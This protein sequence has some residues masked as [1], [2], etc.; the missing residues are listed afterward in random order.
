MADAVRID[1]RNILARYLAGSPPPAMRTMLLSGLGGFLAIFALTVPFALR[2]VLAE[3]RDITIRNIRL[4]KAP[5]GIRLA[6]AGLKQ[7][8]RTPVIGLVKPSRQSNGMATGTTST[9]GQAGLKFSA[10]PLMQ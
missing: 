2:K 1:A 10:T 3:P 5:G 4:D 6:C 7:L 8:F 9:G